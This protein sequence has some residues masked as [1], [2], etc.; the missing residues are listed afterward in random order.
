V[1]DLVTAAWFGVIGACIGSFLNV[2]A[3]RMPRGMSVVW[4][5]SHCPLCGHDIRARDN[6]PV[7]GWLLLRGRCRDCGAA[8][9]PR[10]A[11]VE[12]LMAAAFAWL[13][14]AELQSGAANLPGGPLVADSGAM[15]LVWKP[16]WDLIG[17]YVFH[18]GL[19]SLLMAMALVDRDGRPIPCTLAV[20]ATMAIVI[21]TWKSPVAYPERSRATQVAQIQAPVDALTGVAWGALPMIAGWAVARRRN[22]SDSALLMLNAAVMLGS[23][24]GFLGLRPI[25]RITFAWLVGTVATRG[26]LRGE[27]WRRNVLAPLWPL[28]LVHLVFWKHVAPWLNW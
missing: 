13:A 26:F 9:S 24:G 8:I 6:L 22:R 19:V 5:P 18:A 15:N 20:L 1:L 21:G 11:I 28:A 2:V 12:A 14:Y 10:Y 4:K 7:L 25:V 16:R 3:Y 23:I 17:L 27:T